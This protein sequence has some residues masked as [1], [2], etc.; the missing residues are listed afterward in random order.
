MTKFP[1]KTA[2]L[3]N[4]RSSPFLSEVSEYSE[5]NNPSKTC[6][7]GGR[8]Q[9]LCS[10]ESKYLKIPIQLKLPKFY[11]KKL[12]IRVFECSVARHEKFRTLP[13]FFSVCEL[14]VCAS[15]L[16]ASPSIPIYQGPVTLVDSSICISKMQIKQNFFRFSAVFTAENLKIFFLKKT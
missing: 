3:P 14:F 5:I 6:L 2:Y 9:I 4:F 13:I 11:L 10:A 1:P 16:M 15:E 7:G 12:E 8:A